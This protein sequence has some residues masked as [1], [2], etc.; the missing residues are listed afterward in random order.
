MEP[1]VCK[2]SKQWAV[3]CP[4]RAGT[5]RSTSTRCVDD[6]ALAN[7]K[8]KMCNEVVFSAS[9]RE[10]TKPRQRGVYETIPRQR[11]LIKMELE[12]LLALQALLRKWCLGSQAY[13]EGA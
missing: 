13:P 7:T 9:K 3:M 11:I 1:H 2:P 8:C 12:T 5:S 6:D 4:A 10:S